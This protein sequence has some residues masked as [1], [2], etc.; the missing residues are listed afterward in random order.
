M[1]AEA[2]AARVA[3]LGGALAAFS[4]RNSLGMRGEFIAERWRAG[5]DLGL[6]AIIRSEIAEDDLERERTLALER[7]RNRGDNPAGVAFDSFLDSLF[8]THPYGRRLVG[9]HETVS[10]FSR[11]D[12]DRWRSRY[13]DPRR[14]VFTVVGNVDVDDVARTLE[15]A[16]DGDPPEPLATRVPVDATPSAPVSIRGTN[17][18]NQ[19]HVVIGAMGTTVDDPDRNALQVLT[20]VLAGQGGRL[21]RD[22]R[23]EQSLAYSVSSSNIEG[24]DP[25]HILTYGGTSPEKA[26]RMVEGLHRHLDR[27]LVEPIGADELNRAKRYLT[28]THAVDLQRAGARAMVM[29]LGELFGLGF[30]HFRGYAE[31]VGAVRAEDVQRVACRFLQRESRVEVV[32]GPD[33]H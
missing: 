11:S 12:L 27:L 7:I 13:L 14:L 21:F 33:A 28:G 25:G 9:T 10:G 4:G 29:A 31:R 20:T 2:F 19:C 1:P 17:E 16:L 23:D 18:K 22:L 32:L 3:S 5:L 30:E 15:D 24:L 26:E 6:D 8:P